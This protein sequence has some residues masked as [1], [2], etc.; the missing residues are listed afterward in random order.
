[1]A[2]ASSALR[3]SRALQTW[4]TKCARRLNSFTSCS[5]QRPSSRKCRR[6]SG[7]AANALMQTVAPTG[8]RLKG[9]TSAPAQRPDVIWLDL[10][11]FATG[12]KW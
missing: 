7:A 6:T 10:F 4:Q 1:M 11:C 8:T 2:S 9:Q 5:S 12:K 3:S